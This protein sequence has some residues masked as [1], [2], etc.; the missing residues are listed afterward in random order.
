MK[1]ALLTTALIASFG[2]TAVAQ[3]IEPVATA[4]ATDVTVGTLTGEA[5]IFL[6]VLG[7]AVVI[8]G[9]V[10]GSDSSDGTN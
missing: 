2:T 4:P 7:A 3:G 5:G 9:V 10:A 1:K 6:A 8:A